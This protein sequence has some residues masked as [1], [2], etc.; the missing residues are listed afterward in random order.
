MRIDFDRILITQFSPEETQPLPEE[1]QPLPEETP[2]LSE[3]TQPLFKGSDQRIALVIG[4]SDYGDIPLPNPKNDAKDMARI[5]ASLGF[6]VFQKTNLNQ[7]EMEKAINEF[8]GLIQQR[9]AAVFYFSG[10]GSQVRG[11]NYL[12]S[13]GENIRSEGHIQHKAIKVGNILN[14]MEA[15]EN[16]NNIVILDACREV[17][18][19]WLFN[20][21]LAATSIPERIFIAYATAPGMIVP[22]GTEQNSIYTKHLL[23]AIQME[24]I[25]ITQAFESLR[26]AVEEATNGQQTPW[27]SSSLQEDF[28]FYPQH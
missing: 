28:S 10:Y 15:S 14:N 5:L 11:E 6:T 27:T 13:V 2:S 18:G 4:N 3:K 22:D 8:I 23:E 20:K 21:G 25:T 19:I 7:Q 9:N 24:G 1:T 16:R 17:K 26:K 12:I